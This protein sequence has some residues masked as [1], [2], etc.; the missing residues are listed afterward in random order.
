MTNRKKRVVVVAELHCG[1]RCGLTPPEWQLN[2]DNPM[3]AEWLKLQ[4]EQW[5]WYRR[6]VSRLKP[7]HLLIVLGDVVDGKSQK[8]DGRDSIRP[9]R[10]EQINMGLTCLDMWDAKHIEMVYGTRYH[11]DDWEDDVCTA[12]GDK[13]KIGAHGWAKVNGVTFDIKHKV[14]GSQIPHGR[15]TAILRERLW[16]TEWAT[17]GRQPLADIILRGHVHYCIEASPIVGDRQILCM[18]CPALQGP[19]TE[20]GAEQCSGT[21]D[22]GLVW[23]DITAGGSVEKHVE[24]GLLESQIAVAREY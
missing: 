9:K 5:E 8:A 23:F 13:A 10:Q 12:L 17:A 4:Q 24:I 15:A 22:F 20:F 3:D 21:V 6:I 2:P 1:H 7:V 11:V 19:G 16:N 18:T 14:G